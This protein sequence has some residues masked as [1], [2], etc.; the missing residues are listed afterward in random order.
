MIQK[1]ITGA[2]VLSS[3]AFLLSGTPISSA[4]TSSGSESGSLKYSS[5]IG[6]VITHDYQGGLYFFGLVATG[7]AF[8]LSSGFLAASGFFD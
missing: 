1:I 8:L 6:T 3:G 2:F 7:S 4:G 5:Y